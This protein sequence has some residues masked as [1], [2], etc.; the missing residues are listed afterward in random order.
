VTSFSICIPNFNYARYL[1]AT[2]DSVLGQ[3]HRD[4][5]VLV[6]DNASTD[7]SLDV[8]DQ[9]GDDRVR[10]HV[11][12]RNIGFASNLDRAA[13]MASGDVMIMLSSDDVMA[14]GALDVYADLHARAVDEDKRVVICSTVDVIDGDGERTGAVGPDP[15][16]WHDALRPPELEG[17][18]GAPV[19]VM[20]ASRLLRRCLRQMRNPFNYAATA[21]PREMYDLV[22]GYGASRLM[23]PDK[24]F[25]W[26]LLEVADEAW[27][28]DRPLFGYRWHASNQTALQ[29]TTGALKYLV[30][31]YVT[32]FEVGDE[33]LESVALSRDELVTAFIEHDVGRHGLA[34][35]ARGDR[36]S[37]RR[38]ADFARGAYPKVA[39]SNRK[40]TALRG[41]LALG[42]IGQ[43][44]AAVAYQRSED[45]RQAKG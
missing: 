22:E 28:V 30:D 39:R 37:A 8:I 15:Q 13:R 35:L 42:P 26:R 45:R 43:R 29:S 3:S 40:V 21:Y 38:A 5:E 14:P 9:H 10:L 7:G 31:E 24:W 20:P 11:N 44:I 1:G 25:H 12:K 27:F 4:L 18:G 19:L 41:L 6:S 23:N 32:T 2:L 34:L 17:P 33:M 16:L 36:S